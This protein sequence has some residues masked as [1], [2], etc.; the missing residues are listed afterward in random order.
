[1]FTFC[2]D[3]PHFGVKC[4]NVCVVWQLEMQSALTEEKPSKKIQTTWDLDSF[5][6]HCAL[7][8]VYS[9]SKEP[10]FGIKCIYICVVWQLLTASTEEKSRKNIQKTWDPN[11]FYRRFSKIWKDT[12]SDACLAFNAGSSLMEKEQL[13]LETLFLW[14]FKCG[15]GFFILQVVQDCRCLPD[16]LWSLSDPFRRLGRGHPDTQQFQQIGEEGGKNNNIYIFTY[17]HGY[18][19]KYSTV[20]MFGVAD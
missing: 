17:T 13:V 15:R 7:K 5:Y 19:N 1:M 2:H 6:T 4:A 3:E 18:I 12:H 8:N 16:P 10:H 20:Q 14:S 9:P 11:S